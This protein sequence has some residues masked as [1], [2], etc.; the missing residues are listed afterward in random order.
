MSSEES[1]TTSS[2]IP[3]RNRGSDSIA[4]DLLGN[5]S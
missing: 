1:K 5:N 4:T 2:G 3:R